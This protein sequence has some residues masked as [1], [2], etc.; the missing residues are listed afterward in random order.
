MKIT[1]HGLE[2]SDTVAV[3]PVRGFASTLGENLRSVTESCRAAY[4][5]V[6]LVDNG[7]DAAMLHQVKRLAN[8]PVYIVKEERLGSYYSRNRGVELALIEGFQ[9]ILFTDSDCIVKRDWAIH[10]RDELSDGEI[11]QG[12]SGFE[13]RSSLGHAADRDYQMRLRQWLGRELT[14]GA[15]VGSLDT[16]S[17][18]IKASVFRSVGLFDERFTFAGDALWG[19]KAISLGF[20][21]RGCGEPL[22][23]HRDPETWTGVY[24]KFRDIARILSREVGFLSRSEVLSLLPEHAHL[25]IRKP[26]GPLGW[27]KEILR[28]L[29]STVR[30]SPD[31]A[32]AAYSGLRELGW[33]SGRR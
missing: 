1:G 5:A 19:R 15:T 29:E 12:Y 23:V 33:Y 31:L 3:I 4:G 11:V 17:C 25:L 13:R 7:A 10:M 2:Q 30:R 9:N 20:L 32:T 28:W 27:G 21:I 22:V 18:A 16:R 26:T 8:S 6:I 24:R 14:C